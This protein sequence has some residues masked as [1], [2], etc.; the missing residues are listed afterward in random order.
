[1]NPWRRL[2]SRLV[3]ENRWI[4]VRE[5]RVI[6]PDGGEGIYGVVELRP[7]IGVLALNERNEVALAGQ[8]RYTTEKYSWEIPRG[9]S[10]PGETDLLAAARRELREEAGLIASEWRRLAAVDLNNGVTTDVEH[11]FLATGLTKTAD[12]QDPEEQITIRW[13]P[14]AEAVRMALAGEITECCSV[15]A[16]LIAQATFSSA[17]ASGSRTAAE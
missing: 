13:V 15:A 9:G 7:S 17:P 5:D 8:W 1:M 3:Y 12:R 10:A 11:L 14:F 16:I 2:A 6:R 4:R